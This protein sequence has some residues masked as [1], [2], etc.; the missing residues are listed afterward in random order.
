MVFI[1]VR[2]IITVLLKGFRVKKKITVVI[3]HYNNVSGLYKLVNSIPKSEMIEIVIVDDATDD[4]RSKLL[5]F[6]ER[7]TVHFSEKNIGAGACRNVGLSYVNSEWIIF[8]DSDDY[9][10]PN[11][12][13]IFGAYTESKED[14]IFFNVDSIDLTTGQKSNRCRAVN[15]LVERLVDK[16]NEEIRYS[17][18]VPWGKMIK[19][20][21]IFTY[22]IKFDEV[23]CSNDVFFSLK[24]GHLAESIKGSNKAVYMVTRRSGSLTTNK[25]HACLTCRMD[26]SINVNKYLYAIDEKY[27]QTSYL[28]LLLMYRKVMPGSSFYKLSK[29]VILGRLKIFPKNFIGVNLFSRLRDIYKNN[30]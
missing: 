9:F 16:G 11:A 6:E 12:F 15:D 8:A 17:S 22:N 26:V 2:T 18:A 3:P 23:V 21:L 25:S 30:M 24:A 28:K 27:Y 5:K 14:I 1:Y 19:S 7:C 4:A 10:L 13:D 29:D 20:K